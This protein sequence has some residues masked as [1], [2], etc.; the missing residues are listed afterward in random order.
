MH[1]S[2]FKATGLEFLFLRSTM[3]NERSTQFKNLIDVLPPL[4]ALAQP[5]LFACARGRL[6]KAL[7]T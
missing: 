4:S 3:C 5:S 6:K 7:S 2:P 1:G